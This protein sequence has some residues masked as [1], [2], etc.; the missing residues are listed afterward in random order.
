MTN[1]SRD[2]RPEDRPPG[3]DY[4]DPRSVR[5]SHQ[6]HQAVN[7]IGGPRIRR[8][9]ASS[10]RR[11]MHLANEV[12]P[13]GSAGGNHL[14][15]YALTAD[16][17]AERTLDGLLAEHPGELIRTGKIIFKSKIYIYNVKK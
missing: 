5:G 17:L 12:P 9:R 14:S 8:T 6:A 2:V 7:Q 3:L 13:Q 4:P 10:S 15:D 16:L 11:R 1:P